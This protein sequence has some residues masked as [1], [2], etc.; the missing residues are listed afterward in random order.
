M[1][2]F[3]PCPVLIAMMAQPTGI[4]DTDMPCTVIPRSES[5]RE[6]SRRFDCGGD[7]V[8]RFRLVDKQESPF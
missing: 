1:G 7:D 6:V 3:G 4:E 8:R 5:D 2:T